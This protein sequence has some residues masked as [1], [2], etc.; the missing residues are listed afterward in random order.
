MGLVG[1]H[2]N[3]IERT[4]LPKPKTTFSEEII[5]ELNEHKPKKK[6]EPVKIVK[7]TSI[8]LEKET[9][10]KLNALISIGKGGSVNKLIEQLIE[11]Y[12]YVTLTKEERRNYELI[13]D[14][15]MKSSHLK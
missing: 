6:E 12:V 2:K 11:E 10:L 5:D 8:R 9:Q 3:G 14:I 4:P 7:T 15:K 13:Y 1:Q